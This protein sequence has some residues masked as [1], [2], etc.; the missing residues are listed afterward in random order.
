V[1]DTQIAQGGV[2]ADLVRQQALEVELE[3]I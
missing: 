3:A 2:Y 1:H